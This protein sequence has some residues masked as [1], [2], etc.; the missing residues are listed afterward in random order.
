MHDEV[1][2]VGIA[3]PVHSALDASAIVALSP[4]LPAFSA[5]SSLKTDGHAVPV[6]EDKLTVDTRPEAYVTRVESIAATILRRIDDATVLQTSGA[7]TSLAKLTASF[8]EKS[9][10]GW[11]AY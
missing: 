4:S 9:A 8:Q 2:V 6:A 5:K 3:T 10:G 1:E 11:L 7:E